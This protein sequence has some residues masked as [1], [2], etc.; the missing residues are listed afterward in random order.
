MIWVR[1]WSWPAYRASTVSELSRHGAA[2]CLRPQYRF[3]QGIQLWRGANMA[4]W[5]ALQ[6]QFWREGLRVQTGHLGEHYKRSF[7]EGV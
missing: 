7:G 4:P 1:S 5:R 3:P 2:W 6:A